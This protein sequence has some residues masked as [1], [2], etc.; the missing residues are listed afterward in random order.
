MWKTG[1]DFQRTKWGIYR[2]LNN[3]Q[4][5]RDEIVYFTDFYIEESDCPPNYEESDYGALT[6]S[7][8]STEHYDT[9]GILESSQILLSGSTIEYDS[10]VCIELLSGF[11]AKLNSDFNAYIDGC[12]E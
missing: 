3:D 1:A 10:K 12:N 9:D 6:G 2:S 4:D 8:D 5:L 11:E 7:E